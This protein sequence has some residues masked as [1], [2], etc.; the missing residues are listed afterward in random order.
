MENFDIC[1]D[2]SRLGIDGTVSCSRPMSTTIKRKISCN[3]TLRIAVTT[4]RRF[5]FR[6]YILPPSRIE[7]ANLI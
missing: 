4:S 2:S 5:S 6:A 1:V 7:P 3:L